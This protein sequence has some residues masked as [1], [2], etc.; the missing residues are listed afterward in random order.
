MKGGM[1]GKLFNL[2][3]ILMLL[4]FLSGGCNFSEVED[5]EDE[6]DQVLADIRDTCTGYGYEPG[7]DAHSDCVKEISEKIPE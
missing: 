2:I 6:E 1:M 3:F 5:A 4:V 7:S